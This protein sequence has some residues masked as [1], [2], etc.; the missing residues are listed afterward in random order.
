MIW[1]VGEVVGGLQNSVEV[2]EVLCA[3]HK[4]H[5]AGAFFKQSLPCSSSRQSLSSLS[6]SL[7]IDLLFPPFWLQV[8]DEAYHALHKELPEVTTSVLTEIRMWI[9]QKLSA[10]EEAH[11]S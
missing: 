11:H 2:E 3:V 10:A 7:A 5:V 1:G 6:L 8:Y 9:S 4:L